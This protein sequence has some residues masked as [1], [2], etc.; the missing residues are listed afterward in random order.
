MRAPVELYDLAADPGERTNLAG[1]AALAATEAD[2]RRQLR[3]SMEA[4]DD[5]LLAGPVASPY[6]HDALRR[7]RA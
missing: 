5:P 4:T 7:L 3:A 2:L 1:Q 6:Y